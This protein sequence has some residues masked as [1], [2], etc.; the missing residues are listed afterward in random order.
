LLI[1]LALILIS[2]APP[3]VFFAVA[4]TYTGSG[5]ALWLITWLR[6]RRKADDDESMAA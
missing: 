3:I 5:P 6:Q 1:P 2:L 4:M